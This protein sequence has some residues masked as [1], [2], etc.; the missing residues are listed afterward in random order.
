MLD[1]EDPQPKR[2]SEPVPV[3]LAWL[4]LVASH[5]RSPSAS[6]LYPPEHQPCCPQSWDADGV[7]WDQAPSSCQRA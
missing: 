5:G 3:P 2:P 1:R 7:F 6:A 4:V